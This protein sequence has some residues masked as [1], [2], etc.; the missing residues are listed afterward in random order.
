MRFLVI[1]G[2]PAVGKTTVGQ[3]IEAATGIRLFHNHMSIEP[4]LKFFPFGSPAFRRLV[5]G[6]RQRMFDEVAQSDLPGLCFTF[7]WDL[8]SDGDRAF[9][10]AACEPFVRR[11]AEITFIELR[12]DLSERLSRN[13]SPERLL[14]KPSKR[15]VAQ[16]EASLLKLEQKRLNTNGT[17]PLGHRHLDIDTN[18][19]SSHD[20]AHEILDLLG[21]GRRS[22]AGF[23]SVRS[24][25]LDG[26]L[27]G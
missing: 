3:L 24:S 18:G 27:P 6:F 1:F 13:R 16:S 23:A 2:P 19:R 20:V 8:D 5:D 11:G 17:I 22:D 7:V 26:D 9:L 25:R 4:V 10:E 14:E 21:M 12:A 15:D